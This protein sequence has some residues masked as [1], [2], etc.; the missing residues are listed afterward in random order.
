MTQLAKGQCT[1]YY[2]HFDVETTV[3]KSKTPPQPSGYESRC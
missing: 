3:N 1:F 2:K